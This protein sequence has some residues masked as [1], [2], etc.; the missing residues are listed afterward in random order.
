VIKQLIPCPSVSG[1][2]RHRKSHHY[3]RH[4]S[5]V[6]LAVEI[7]IWTQRRNG[8]KRRTELGVFSAVQAVATAV[9]GVTL[10][11]HSYG[12]FSSAHGCSPIQVGATE[13]ATDLQN[14]CPFRVVKS[15]PSERAKP[16]PAR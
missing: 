5:R 14:G 15:H 2:T 16:A 6:A 3:A 1:S 8:V 7:W 10:G 9:Y 11:R 4:A 13:G 12:V